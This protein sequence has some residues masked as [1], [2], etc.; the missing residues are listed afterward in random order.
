VLTGTN[1][2]YSIFG[3][4]A[5]AW[6]LA[7]LTTLTLNGR[8]TDIDAGICTEGKLYRIGKTEADHY[9]VGCAVKDYFTSDGTET[10]DA[11]NIVLEVTHLGADAVTIVSTP[12]GATQDWESV[13][14]GFDPNDAAMT[15]GFDLRKFSLSRSFRGRRR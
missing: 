11:N 3:D 7:N 5:Y 4:V 9:F 14:D 1:A 10:N 13:D 2:K 12:G 8:V 15:Y 6:L